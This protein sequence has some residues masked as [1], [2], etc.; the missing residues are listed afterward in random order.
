M[1]RIKDSGPGSR[2]GEPKVFT[3][4][5]VG[6]GSLPPRKLADRFGRFPHRPFLPKA[7]E[8]HVRADTRGD[9]HVLLRQ[10]R[11]AETTPRRFSKTHFWLSAY[12]LLPSALKDSI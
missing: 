12:L 11:R 4:P 9:G 10:P 1:C 8:G 2:A 5:D 3:S 7:E 6:V